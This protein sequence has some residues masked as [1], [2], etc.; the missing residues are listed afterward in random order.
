MEIVRLYQYVII[1]LGGRGG[2]R[3][4]EEEEVQEE[5]GEERKDNGNVG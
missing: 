5:E 3:A 2:E 4:E 1:K